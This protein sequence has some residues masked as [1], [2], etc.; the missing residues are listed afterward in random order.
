MLRS[1]RSIDVLR[2]DGE[3]RIV[4]SFTIPNDGRQMKA[5]CNTSLP[6]ISLEDLKGEARKVWLALSSWQNAYNRR[7]LEGALAAYDPNIL[8]LYAGGKPDTFKE[9]KSSYRAT[10]GDRTRRRSVNLELEEIFTI[11][12]LAVVRDHWTSKSESAAGAQARRSRGIEIW[13]R[14]PSGDW[15]LLRYLSYPLCESQ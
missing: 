11:G 13:H 2:K 3:W 10:F 14:V 5:D 9:M 8:G 6:R 15:K 1:N 12:D 4:R 7:D